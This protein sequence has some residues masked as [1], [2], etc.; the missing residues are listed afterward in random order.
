MATLGRPDRD[1]ARTVL[2]RTR[3]DE[4]GRVVEVIDPLGRSVVRR[5]Y[6]RMDRVLRDENTDGGLTTSVLDADGRPV[7][8]E[9]GDGRRTLRL[10]DDLGRLIEVW[11]RDRAAD[12]VTLR[13][14]I[15]YGDVLPDRAAAR[16][17]NLLGPGRRSTR[18]RPACRELTGY[19]SHGNVVA[20]TR[21]T[22]QMR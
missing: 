16:Q 5:R 20:R 18:T 14:R 19:D 13:E 2:T 10:Y 3:Y 1:P 15:T 7:D 17:A 6:D 12:P 11:A 21:R 8:V 9:D 4:L 22:S